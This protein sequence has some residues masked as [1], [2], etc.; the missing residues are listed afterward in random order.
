MTSSNGRILRRVV[1]TEGGN[2]DIDLDRVSACIRTEAGFLAFQIHDDADAIT[3]ITWKEFTD[4]VYK[5]FHMGLGA[6]PHSGGGE[7]SRGRTGA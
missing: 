5:C 2:G 6:E 3:T 7:M 4:L 1:F